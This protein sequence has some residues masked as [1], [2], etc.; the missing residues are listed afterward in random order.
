MKLNMQIIADHLKHMQPF[1]H[2]NEALELN[3]LSPKILD[4]DTTSFEPGYL[5]IGK[6]ENFYLSKNI[7][8]ISAFLCIGTIQTEDLTGLTDAEFIMINSTY[9][10]S[11]VFNTVQSIFDRYNFWDNSLDKAII[12]KSSFQNLLDIAC[13]VLDNPI[14]LMDAAEIC[15]AKSGNIP[16]NYDNTI[17]AEIIKYGQLRVECF[18]KF[19][20]AYLNLLSN[21]RY[22]YLRK[23]KTSPDNMEMSANIFVDNSRVALLGLVDIACPFTYGQ[24]CLVNYLASVFSIAFKTHESSLYSHTPLEYIILRLISGYNIKH[25]IVQYQLSERNWKITDR[26]YFFYFNFCGDGETTVA[27]YDFQINA[28][29]QAIPNSIVLRFDDSI[30]AVLRANNKYSLE[31]VLI[32]LKN[33]LDKTHCYCGI[34]SPFSNFYT[35]NDN[36][37]QAFI[38]LTHG[39]VSDKNLHIFHYSDFFIEHIIDLCLKSVNFSML[40][41]PDV[42]KLNEYD[43]INDTDYVTD[44]YTYLICGK[45]ISKSAEKLHLHRNTFIYR[46][47]KI[48]DLLDTD[49][50]N[51]AELLH[52]IISYL[53]IKFQYH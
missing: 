12:N 8:C 9:E 26:Y 2:I 20:N 51:D 13:E 27:T 31:E 29:K 4:Q 35:I 49:M 53:I 46:L 14:A 41:H 15:L 16:E 32:S 38:A 24:L 33:I 28:I 37:N 42:I 36:Y 23:S 1:L 50:S 17:W 30:I 47:N 43:R 3:L 25:D 52:L 18:S 40:C 39:Y 21:S 5:Y 44:L 6:A 45:S 34:S 19:D 11:K 7:D 10:F 22:A 48:L